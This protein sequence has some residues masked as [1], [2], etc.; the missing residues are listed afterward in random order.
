MIEFLQF[1]SRVN[2]DEVGFMQRRD[3]LFFLRR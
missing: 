1:G 3:F 2:L